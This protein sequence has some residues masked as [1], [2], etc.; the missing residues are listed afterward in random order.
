MNNALRVIL[1]QGSLSL[2]AERLLEP[3][4]L[5]AYISRVVDGLPPRGPKVQVKRVLATG[6]H[7]SDEPG[8]LFGLASVLDLADVSGPDP[9]A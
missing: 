1:R 8:E 5:A 2:F 3:F 4:D 9:R 7:I 6:G